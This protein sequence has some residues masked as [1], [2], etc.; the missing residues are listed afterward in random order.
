VDLALGAHQA[1]RH[2]GGRHQKRAGDLLGG[3][4]AQGA[5]RQRHL[6]LGRQR[7]VTAGEDQAHALVRNG[8]VGLTRQIRIVA[9]LGDVAELAADLFETSGAPERIDGL[10]ARCGDDPRSR[11]RRTTRTRP[12]IDGNGE[13]VLHRLLGYVEVA[14][15]PDDRRQ[16][17]A[18]L[19]GVETF[20]IRAFHGLPG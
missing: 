14:D 17:T 16:H 9:Q 1:L 6:R 8:R 11:V 3:Q 4:P 19:F 20:D 13:R 18:E 12:L 5:Q 7:R 15:E 2:C 10:M